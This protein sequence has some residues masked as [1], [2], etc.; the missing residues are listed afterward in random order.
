MP[1]RSPQKLR[2]RHSLKGRVLAW[3]LIPLLILSIAHLATIYTENQKTSRELFDKML[4]ALAL[5]ISEYAISTEGDL[6]TVGLL[7]LI[8][9]TTNDKLYYKVLG[10]GGSYLVG[11]NDMPEPKAGLKQINNHIE[12]YDAVYLGQPVRVIA[13]STFSERPGQSGWTSTF[14]AQTL[15]DRTNYVMGAMTDNFFRLLFLIATV[16]IIVPLGISLALKPLKQLAVALDTRDLQDL[17][18]LDIQHLPLELKPLVETTNNLLSRLSHQIGLTKRFL[19]NAS[20]QLRTPITALTLQCT[21]AVRRAETER[22]KEEARKIKQNVDRIARLT[23]QLLSLSYSESEAG[24]KAQKTYFD[25][26]HV[27][28]ACIHRS[29]QTENT[30]TLVEG[31]DSVIIFGN[32]QLLEELLVNLLD[33]AFKYSGDRGKI[34]VTTRTENAHALLEVKDEGPGIPKDLRKLVTERFFRASH[35]QDGSG[36]GLAIVKEIT[37]VHGGQI[38]ITDGDNQKGTCVRCWFPLAAGPE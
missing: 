8:R 6:L 29:R 34:Y 36:L 31:L 37:H 9:Q 4:V 26:A 23:N 17:S 27:A 32:E 15:K 25:L 10:P 33:N 22:D 2:Y 1:L 3:I 30:L 11:Y 20:H 16:S 21:F 24:N 28:K 5:S 35:D 18:P 7:E 38:E 13:V 14:V 19:E 12:L